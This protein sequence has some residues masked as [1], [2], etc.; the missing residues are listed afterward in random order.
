MSLIRYRPAA[1]LAS[2]VDSLW[3]SHRGVPQLGWE[4]MLPC[5][6]T[7]LIFAL[8]DGEYSWK[9]QS[10][11]AHWTVWTRG[12]VHGP[13]WSYFVSGS[14]PCGAIA[15]VSF[16]VGAAGALLGLPTSELSGHHVPLDDIWGSR[17]E[18]IR[19][20]L[21]AIH[22]PMAIV[23]ALERELL[24]RLTRPLLMHPAIAHALADP[25]RGWGFTRIAGVQQ[26]AGYSAKHFIALFRGAVGVTP[27]HYYRMKRFTAALEILGTRPGANLADLAASVGF[28]DQSHLIRE[29]KEFA[30]VTPTQYRPSS[31]DSVLHHMD[32]GAR[33]ADR[34]AQ[35]IVTPSRSSRTNTRRVRHE[36]KILL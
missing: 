19:Q 20:R 30:G 32:A 10:C 22:E 25:A 8:H 4:H 36:V 29:F 13:Q 31:P 14:K 6:C 34:H 9:P 5:A 26:S 3:W 15:G 33:P 2:Y 28:A 16:R 21:L 35:P 1:P 7:Q 23:H 24:A 11:D 17:A 18:S 12:V 27:K